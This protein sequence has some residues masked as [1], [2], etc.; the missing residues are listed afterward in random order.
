MPDTQSVAR[1]AVS[2][3]LGVAAVGLVG[4]AVVGGQS[5]TT[6]RT[7]ITTESTQAPLPQPRMVPAGWE[8]PGTPQ[9][10]RIPRLDVSAEVLPILARGETLVPPADPTELGWWADGARPGD[11]GRALI[12]GHTVHTGGGALDDLETLERGDAVVVE[13]AKGR[14]RWVVESVDVL[15]KGQL[16][17]D[18]QRLFRQEGPARLVL[19]TCEDWDGS[20][21][22]SNVVVVARPAWSTP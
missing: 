6:A 15:G 19:L 22:L 16:T 21:Y 10:L 1:R 14:T 9:Q 7:E 13:D 17:R 18:A 12:A 8:R 3:L 20:A 11:E 2:A 4:F 5:A